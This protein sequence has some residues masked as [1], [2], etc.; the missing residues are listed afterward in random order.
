MCEATAILFPFGGAIQHPAFH[1]CPLKYSDTSTFSSQSKTDRFK[2]ERCAFTFAKSQRPIF[3]LRV[4]G[5]VVVFVAI[6][7]GLGQG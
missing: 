5:F 1:Y 4:E 3:D 6:A 7:Q 2:S